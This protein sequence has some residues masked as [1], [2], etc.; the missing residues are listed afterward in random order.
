MYLFHFSFFVLSFS[1]SP[2]LSLSLLPQCLPTGRFDNMTNQLSIVRNII[3][4]GSDPLF[5]LDGVL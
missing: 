1:P 2:R 4:T 3:Q 5:V